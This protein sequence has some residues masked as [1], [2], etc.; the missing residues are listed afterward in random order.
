MHGERLKKNINGTIKNDKC[1]FIHETYICTSS[2]AFRCFL[3]IAC[4]MFQLQMLALVNHA[5]ME[6]HVLSQLIVSSA[7]ALPG[8][9][10]AH[11]KHVSQY[12]HMNAVC[13]YLHIQAVLAQHVSQHF[14]LKSIPV[15][16][17]SQIT[18][19]K[20]LHNA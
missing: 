19:W 20:Y 14:H 1:W 3:E 9:K 12:H 11:V 15:K 4:D 13:Q 18:N 17:V 2:Y 7:H 8:F 16:H 6:E 5:W 10:A